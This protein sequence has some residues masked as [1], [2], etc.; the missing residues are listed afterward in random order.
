MKL[1]S[2]KELL[3]WYNCYC[4]DVVEGTDRHQLFADCLEITRQEAKNLS[5]KV[6]CSITRSDYIK[7]MFNI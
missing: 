3:S 4:L 5:Y 6:G 1:F 7:L 2:G